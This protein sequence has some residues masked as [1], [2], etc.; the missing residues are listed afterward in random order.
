MRRF[1][2]TEFP[3]LLL[4]FLQFPSVAKEE[5]RTKI[6]GKNYDKFEEN[7]DCRQLSEKIYQDTYQTT[8]GKEERAESEITEE[9]DVV[10]S[11]EE[12]QPIETNNEISESVHEKID[13]ED[14]YTRGSYAVPYLGWEIK[15]MPTQTIVRGTTIFENGEI[16]GKQGH[17]VFIR[18]NQIK[19]KYTS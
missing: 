12:D 15:G 14:L 4:L 2:G 11:D 9:E 10:D 13:E 17:C 19:P 6:Q 16:T 18:P 8:T 1:I 5:D 3:F 7:R